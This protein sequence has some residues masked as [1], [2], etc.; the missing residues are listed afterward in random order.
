[1]TMSEQLHLIQDENLNP[2][3]KVLGVG[4]GGSNAVNYM[5]KQGIVG[6][7][8]LVCNTDA[9]ALENSPVTTKIQ[10]GENLTDGR[11]AGNNPEIG[12]KAAEESF[13]EIRSILEKDTRMLFITAGMGGGTG[14]GAAPVIA[15]ISREMGILTVGIVTIPFKFEGQTRLRQALTGLEEMEKEVDCLLVVNNERLRK[16][17][18]DLKLTEAFARADDVLTVAAKGIAEIITV[19]GHV[20]VDFADVRTVMKDS[21]VALMG[22]ATSAGENRG[23]HAI[24]KALNSPLLNS[25]DIRG[26]A[27][28][29]LNVTSGTEEFRL[30]ELC[31]ITDYVQSLIQEEVQII[32]GNGKDPSLGERIR[33]VI[34]ATG[35]EKHDIH[36]FY[37]EKKR[38]EETQVLVLEEPGQPVSPEMITLSEPESETTLEEPVFEIIRTSSA[39]N[40]QYSIF[41]EKDDTGPEIQNNPVATEKTIRERAA[42]IREKEEKQK[43]TSSSSKKSRNKQGKM[44]GWIQTKLEG[45][46]NEEIN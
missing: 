30:D 19:H 41:G 21:G 24:K 10:I 14:T 1:M 42:L 7:D 3:I 27:N 43:S 37:A 8:F 34:I 46:F 4:G 15:K 39:S 11:G 29:L 22:S 18:G 33:V 9:Q 28:I 25:N 45:F 36:E 35:F 16:I 44:S 17:F 31:S 40:G 6:V 32:W 2:I 12:K 38:D 5:F 23:L 20:N 26:A 13:R